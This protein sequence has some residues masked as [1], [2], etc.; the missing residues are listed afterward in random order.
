MKTKIKIGSILT[1][2]NECIMSSGNQKTLTIGRGYEVIE[3]TKKE[4]CVLDD[5]L[6]KHYF[7]IKD[8]YRFFIT[9]EIKRKIINYNKTTV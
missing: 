4:I 7:E 3:M 9:S 6:K 5:D 2:I 1:S 8:L